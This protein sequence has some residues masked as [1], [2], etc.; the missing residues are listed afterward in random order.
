MAIFWAIEYSYDLNETK[1]PGFQILD[2]NLNTI[3]V[4]DA[5]GNVLIGGFDYSVI[6]DTTAPVW[7]TE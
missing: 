7:W 3:K 5:D 1:L 4:T 6:G 2:D